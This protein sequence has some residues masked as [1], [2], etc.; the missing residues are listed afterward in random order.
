MRGV[1][2]AGLLMVVAAPAMAQSTGTNPYP[3]GSPADGQV[4]DPNRR[5]IGP[6]QGAQDPPRSEILEGW[7]R[8]MPRCMSTL[9]ARRMP[10]NDAQQVCYK[11]L[12]D[13]RD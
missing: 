10:E 4:A 6:G 3:A 11:I 12:T 5:T 8:D 1:V 9:R 7:S 2:L 13:L